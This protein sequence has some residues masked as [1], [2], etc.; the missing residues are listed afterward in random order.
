ML[1]RERTKDALADRLSEFATM[2]ILMGQ[3][4]MKMPL[5]WE[6][7]LQGI[8]NMKCIIVPIQLLF[9]LLNFIYILVHKHTRL[10]LFYSC[11]RY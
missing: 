1:S 7:L 11:Y 3:Q 5:K 2:K 9:Y 8:L 10:H 6:V 4:P